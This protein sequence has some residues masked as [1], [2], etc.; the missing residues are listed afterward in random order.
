M[1]D[2]YS[3]GNRRGNRP[4]YRSHLYGALGL[5]MVSLDKIAWQRTLMS[6]VS[7]RTLLI[8]LPNT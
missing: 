5:W 2:S 3:L 7:G 6:A 1:V 8:H 4:D